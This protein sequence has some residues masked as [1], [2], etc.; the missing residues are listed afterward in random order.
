M[1]LRSRYTAFLIL[2]L[3]T[4][5]GWAACL[6]LFSSSPGEC[7]SQS[8]RVPVAV[9]SP[10]DVAS[11]ARNYPIGVGRNRSWSCLHAA[12]QDLLRW[13]GMDRQADYWRSHFGGGAN[14]C[15]V[16]AIADQLGLRH[17]E[18]ETGDE[19]FLDFCATNRLGAAIYWEVQKPH[20]HAI[21][22]CGY[23]GPYAVLLGTNR[24]V[25]TRMP[26]SDFLRRWHE[27][28]GGAF[29]ILP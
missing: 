2:L 25:I 12:V 23:D 8:A 21:V 16:A 24:P 5:A 14:V 7:P 3:A 11:P 27:C 13:R 15:D 20:D 28:D 4:L 6:A 29:T 10:I 26:K 22:F 19:S 18:T 1:I 17:A 9:P